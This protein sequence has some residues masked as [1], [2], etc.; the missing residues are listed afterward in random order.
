MPLWSLDNGKVEVSAASHI[1]LFVLYAFH[2][3]Y[4]EIEQV[5]YALMFELFI[6]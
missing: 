6:Q 5:F 2:F 4:F 1:P 3:F